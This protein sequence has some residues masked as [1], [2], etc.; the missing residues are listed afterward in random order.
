MSRS[1]GGF[2]KRVTTEKAKR[3]SILVFTEGERTETLY[4]QH[5]HRRYRDNIIVSIDDFHGGPLQLVR[6]ASR[7]RRIDLKEAR[8]G[9]GDEFDQYWCVFDVDEHPNIP[10]AVQ[11][12]LD[13]EINLAISNPCIELWF[14]LHFEA[15]TGAIHRHTVQRRSRGLLKCD[16]MLTSTALENLAERYEAALERA[17]ALDRKHE[18]DGSPPRSNPSSEVWRLV[19]E[20]RRARPSG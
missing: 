6:E 15:Q 8:R 17:R 9:R 11:L 16:K 10:E 19:E 4:V 20:I 7:Q 3:H 1:R 13:N 2:R 14:V 12:A 18:G 5:W